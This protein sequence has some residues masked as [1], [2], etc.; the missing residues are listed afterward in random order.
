MYYTIM[1]VRLTALRSTKIYVTHFIRQEFFFFFFLTENIIYHT[2]QTLDT[3]L[4][5]VRALEY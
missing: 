2:A 1:Y 4:S 5:P 3:R